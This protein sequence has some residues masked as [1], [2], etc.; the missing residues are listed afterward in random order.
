MTS[1]SNRLEGGASTGFIASFPSRKRCRVS[2]RGNINQDVTVVSTSA[3]FN[4]FVQHVPGG[5][6]DDIAIRQPH[7]K[8]TGALGDEVVLEMNFTGEQ[9]LRPL[10]LVG[11][12]HQGG[13]RFGRG[14][15]FL[16]NKIQGGGKRRPV[17]RSVAHA[18]NEINLL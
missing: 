4:P 15:R 18:G 13:G 2:V 10:T 3:N 14:R 12:S 5:A 8:S 1:Q 11:A 17:K 6:R 16:L 9:E 7:E